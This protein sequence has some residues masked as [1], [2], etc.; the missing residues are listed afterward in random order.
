MPPRGKQDAQQTIKA[1]KFAMQVIKKAASIVQLT[2]GVI[3][4]LQGCAMF[5]TG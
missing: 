1:T 5:L 4:R 3:Q 2:G